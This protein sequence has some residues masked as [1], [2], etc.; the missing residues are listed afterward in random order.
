MLNV[1]DEGND[2]ERGF[3][4]VVSANQKLVTRDFKTAIDNNT[5][6]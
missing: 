1:P 6:R 3:A 2:P 4:L 5:R